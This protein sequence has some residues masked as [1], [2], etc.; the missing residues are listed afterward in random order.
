MKKYL[1]PAAVLF[2]IIFLLNCTPGPNPV[3]DSAGSNGNAAGFWKGL[4]HGFILL[5]TFILSLFTDSVQVYEVHNSGNWYNFGYFLGIMAF[6]GGSSGSA[7][8]K[9]RRGT[10][11]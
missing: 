1:L 9:T 8:H 10:D 6:F 4:W 3:I 2:L 5:F 11:K 7:C